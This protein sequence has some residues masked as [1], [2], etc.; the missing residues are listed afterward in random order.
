MSVK[1]RIK[2]RLAKLKAAGHAPDG[3]PVVVQLPDDAPP[4]EQIAGTVIRVSFV[5]LAEAT[6]STPLDTACEQSDGTSRPMTGRQGSA[7]S[8]HVRCE[9]VWGRLPVSL[10][11]QR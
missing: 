7:K 1:Q 10:S 5:G 6:N 3:C 4:T 11:W 9:D 8:R 2:R